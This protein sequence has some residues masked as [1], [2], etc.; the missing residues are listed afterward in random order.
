MRKNAFI[1]DTFP[2]FFLPPGLHAF[3][4]A[5]LSVYLAD[6]ASFIPLLSDYGSKCVFTLGRLLGTDWWVFGFSFFNN[7]ILPDPLK[8]IRIITKPF[9][10]RDSA[11]LFAAAGGPAGLEVLVHHSSVST[12]SCCLLCLPFS[13]ELPAHTSAA[14][15]RLYDSCD[16]VRSLLQVRHLQTS[17]L[18]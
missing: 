7:S 4:S 15:L 6:P 12:L 13:M 5:A 11:G 10:V 18:M 8:L 2:L 16:V 9:Y 3:L 1:S 14:V 17:S